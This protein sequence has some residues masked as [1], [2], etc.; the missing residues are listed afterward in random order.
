MAGEQRRSRWLHFFA[1]NLDT[2]AIILKYLLPASLTG[3]IVGWATWFTGIFQQHA[4]A[5]WIYATVIGAMIG[6]FT[7]ALLA[8]SREKMQQVKFRNTVF[9][10][11]YLNPLDTLFTTRRVRVVDLSPPIGAVIRGKTFVDCDIMGPAN[12]MFEDCHFQGNAGDVVDAIIIKPGMTPRNGFGFQN[13]IFRECRFYLVTFMVPEPEY[14][15]FKPPAHGGLNWITERPDQP[16]LPM[17][18]VG[19]Q[20]S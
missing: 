20:P 12:I 8:Y 19:P 16:P 10:S 5:S 4:P 7:T 2:A 15:K 1:A 17:S 11:T 3:A 6:A 13:C 18:I 14:D 9:S